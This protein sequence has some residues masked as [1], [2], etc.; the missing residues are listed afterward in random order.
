MPPG[1][2]FDTLRFDEKGRLNFLFPFM[3][4]KNHRMPPYLELWL[5][6]RDAQKPVTG[7]DWHEAK[8]YCDWAGKRLPTEAEWEKAARGTDARTYP[9][10]ESRP[11]SGMA[12]FGK[13]YE[14]EKV[15]TENLKAVGSYE[16]GKSPY[17]AY[18]MAGNVHEWVADWSDKY[19]Y[20]KSPH[21]NPQG[22]SSG[23]RKI[24]RGG[25]WSH[26]PEYLRSADREEGM[27]GGDLRLG[28]R[29]AQDAL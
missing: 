24:L 27:R 19:Y 16:R 7:I 23:E 12:N 11:N 29:C 22:P 25:S 6:K 5:M 10:G 26:S 9:W 1:D 15:Y 17:G 8:L 18:D 2:G 20:G 28:F 13:S 3:T 4:Q 21:A 14:P